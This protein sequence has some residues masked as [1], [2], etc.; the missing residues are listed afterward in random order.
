M[1]LAAG[2]IGAKPQPLPRMTP[3]Q[4]RADIDFVARELPRRH[5]NAFHS[6][7][8]NEFDAAI[9]ALRAR[10]GESNDDQM[11]VGLMRITAIVGDGH[12][13]VRLP[14]SSRLFPITIAEVGSEYRVVRGA[15]AAA[16]LV[17]GRLI[18]IDE[19]SIDEAAVRIR[20]ILPQH[21][22]EVLLRAFTPP[23]FSFANVLRGLGVTASAERARFTVMLDE[24]TERSAEV[25]A[26]DRATTPRW[27]T[28]TSN[29][30]LAR[31][32][33]GEG[34]WFTWLPEAATVYV[35]FRT[36]EDLRSKSRELWSFVDRHPVEKIAID[37]RQNGGGDFNVGRKYMV[38]ELA[39]RPK[40]RGYVMIGGRTFSAALKNAIDFREIARA[41][42]VGETIGERPNSYSE[43]DEMTL[44]QSRIEISYSTRYYEF[45]PHDGLVTPDQEIKPTWAD[46]VAG[47]DPVLDWII[48]R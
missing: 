13:Y 5:K 44:P 7:T 23:W 10:A 29:P 16:D 24:G 30:P 22:S 37:L 33:P 35:N 21:E 4:W 20:T 6:I 2:V 28:L 39:R 15:G 19:T 14:S 40:I 32:R 34:F 17:G 36:Y 46:W 48:E 26:M 27:R 1:F 25:T 11:I 42:L 45:L 31:Q 12:T 43:N 3:E 18:R 9:A 38:D 41:T 8:R 47:R